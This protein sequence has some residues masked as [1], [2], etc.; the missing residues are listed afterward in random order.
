MKIIFGL[1]HLVVGQESFVKPAEV[2]QVSWKSLVASVPKQAQIIQ[3]PWLFWFAFYEE[4][5]RG[6]LQ[7]DACVTWSTFTL[8]SSCFQPCGLFDYLTEELNH[9]WGLAHYLVAHWG[10]QRS[11]TKL[12]NFYNQTTLFVLQ[13]DKV[14]I[15]ILVVASQKLFHTCSLKTLVRYKIICF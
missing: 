4:T 3:N 15:A 8:C 5:K 12:L 1:E 10:Y 13:S 9:P 11:K 2:L 6:L 14:S 7:V